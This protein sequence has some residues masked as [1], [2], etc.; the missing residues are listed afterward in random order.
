VESAPVATRSAGGEYRGGELKDRIQG[1][2]WDPRDRVRCASIL[3]RWLGRIWRE[4]AT[5][6]AAGIFI[7]VLRS[8]DARSNVPSEMLP[9]Y[10]GA[11]ALNTLFRY[12]GL[13]RLIVQTNP[14]ATTQSFVHDIDR[15]A[16]AGGSIPVE[17]VTAT[18]ELGR[19][20][21]SVADAFGRPIELSRFIGASAL[22]ESRR[23]DRLGRLTGLTDPGGSVWS[24]GYDL[25]GLRTS[26]ND[27]DLGIWTY[28]YDLGGRL[29]SQKDARQLTTTLTYD[30]LGR[31][32]TKNAPRS[33]SVVETTTNTYDQPRTGFFNIGHLTT[34]SK[35]VGG[36]LVASQGFDHDGEGRLAKQTWTVDGVAYAAT[37]GFAPGG[38][39]LWKTFPDGDSVGSTASRWVYD[40][41]GRLF[42]VP[43]I[44]SSASYDADGQTKQI[45]YSNGV[46]TTFSYD[47]ERRWLDRVHHANPSGTLLRPA[48]SSCSTMSETT[49]GTSLR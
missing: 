19:Q 35:T 23:Y 27:P 49:S 38:E 7:E 11:V 44:A 5:G 48:R 37:T 22:T 16:S 33:V 12:G 6:P 21:L 25:R 13:D 20:T 34:A 17:K 39:I 46:S 4:G 30:G 29:T 47:P 36:V 41:A 14:D 18:D 28:S 32:L 24:Y 2:P 42:A 45:A 10:T 15:R 3:S 1:G 31:V 9:R 26:A 43:G 40:R 8:F